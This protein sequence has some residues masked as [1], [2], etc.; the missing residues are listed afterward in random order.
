ML[1]IQS[2]VRN[3][4]LK[5]IKYFLPPSWKNNI[6]SNSFLRFLSAFKTVSRIKWGAK[7]RPF[8]WISK[9]FFSN[10]FLTKKQKKGFFFDVSPNSTHLKQ[11]V[12]IAELKIHNFFSSQEFF[13]F[14]KII[15]N[16]LNF[17][18]NPNFPPKKPKFFYIT[19]VMT[20]ILAQT[21]SR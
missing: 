16:V 5:F 18:K 6:F 11:F 15:S 10:N 12:M 9:N 2:L 1:Q 14:F 4:T 13:Y 21:K 7:W 17:S 20:F 19:F 3:W 8:P